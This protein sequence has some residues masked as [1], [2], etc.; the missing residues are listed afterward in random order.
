M[1]AFYSIELPHPPRGK[2]PALDQLHKIESVLIAT[3]D[4]KSISGELLS[5][6][7]NLDAISLRD[8]EQTDAYELKINQIKTLQ[9][10]NSRQFVLAD[11]F[12]NEHSADIS[13][14][15]ERQ[16][17][18]ILFKDDS[19]DIGETLG[20]VSDKNGVHLFVAQAF[21][22]YVHIFIPFS[23]IKDHRIGAFLG[24]ILIDKKV[25]TKEQLGEGLELQKEFRS[26]KL[27][28]ILKEQAIVSTEQ[29]EAILKKQ[30]ARPNIRLG[31]ALIQDGVI[32]EEQLNDALKTQKLNRSKP[33]GE[34]LTDMGVVSII[35]IR[36]T[37][38]SKLGIPFVNLRQFNIEANITNQIPVKIARRH[39]AMPLCIQDNKLIIAI[40]DPMNRVAVEDIRF[41][42]K[43]FVEPIMA[44]EEDIEWAINHHYGSRITDLAEELTLVGQDDEDEEFD[45]EVTDS[46]NALVKIVNKM[47]MDAY[48]A[49]ASDIHIEPSSGK[50]KLIVRFRK[51]GSL[52]PYVELPASYRNALVSRIK[53]MC[54]LDISE[55]RKPQD[56]KIEF[57]KFGP[58]SIELR[59]ATL[60]TAGGVEDVVLRVL[61]NGEPLP[62]EQMNLNQYNLDNIKSLVFSVQYMARSKWKKLVSMLWMHSFRACSNT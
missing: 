50:K 44:T 42:T 25:V 27:G 37:L 36:K 20:H 34:I 43:I 45:T 52:Q 7:A 10:V 47:I 22:N 32:S 35:E 17:Y 38:A 29:L 4:G 13:M 31:E 61:S 3:V 57:R 62:L 30:E 49:G 40:E 39:R 28:E 1:N 51:D 2:T 5:Y 41:H 55:R 54:D 59:V 53:I 12:G 15:S 18:E 19:N 21:N 8:N 56:G 26:Q 60:P 14:P 33:L 58:A 9:L 46:D 23:A 6:S 11:E 24:Q 16:E 48:Q